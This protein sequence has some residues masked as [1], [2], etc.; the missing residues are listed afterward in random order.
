M[1]LAKGWQETGEEGVANRSRKGAAQLKLGV[2]HPGRP[3]VHFLTAP[4]RGRHN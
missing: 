1:K 3:G 4:E 2:P